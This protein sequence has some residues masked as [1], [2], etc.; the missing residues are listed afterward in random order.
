[1]VVI[2]GA[3]QAGK[4]TLAR[5]VVHDRP[6]VDV[7]YL[8]EAVVRAAAEADPAAFVRHDIPDLLPGRSETIELWPLSQGEIGGSSDDFVSAVFERGVDCAVSPSG[9]RRNDY[10]ERALT[11]SGCRAADGTGVGPPCRASAPPAGRLHRQPPSEE[12]PTKS[13]VKIGLAAHIPW[14]P[15]ADAEPVAQ[16]VQFPHPAPRPTVQVRHK[17]SCDRDVTHLRREPIGRVQ[18]PDRLGVACALGLPVGAG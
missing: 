11:P 3:R 8:D 13:P 6:G 14:T 15:A 2:N 16:R 7:R 18:C 4:S 1:M 5:L 9:L 10:L 17:L 12:H